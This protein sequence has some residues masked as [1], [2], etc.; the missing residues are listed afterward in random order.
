MNAKFLK[1]VPHQEN[2]DDV[3]LAKRYETLSRQNR[4]ISHAPHSD[5]ITREANTQTS[6]V[7]L[8]TQTETQPPPPTVPPSETQTPKYVVDDTTQTHEDDDHGALKHIINRYT[9]MVQ[10]ILTFLRN[11][12]FA[13]RGIYLS[14]PKGKYV[15]DFVDRIM[16]YRLTTTNDSVANAIRELWFDE[17]QRNERSDASVLH[18]TLLQPHPTSELRS[19]TPNVPPAATRKRDSKTL[20]NDT[21]VAST[22]NRYVKSRKFQE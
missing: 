2:D 20:A 10:E 5:K 17:M 8:A 18:S 9:G 1:L 14:E 13:F 16:G 11:S 15:G 21:P 19:V 3:W 6:K 12:G 4:G 22:V 7:E